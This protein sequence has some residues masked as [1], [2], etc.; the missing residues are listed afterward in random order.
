MTARLNIASVNTLLGER[1]GDLARELVGADPTER[2]RDEWRFR[3]KGSLAVM[4]GGPRRGLW[5]DFECGCGGDPLGLVAHLRR[6]T[7]R[8]AFRWA[9]A[10]L[11]ALPGDVARP[12]ALRPVEPPYARPEASDAPDLRH[13]WS[14]NLGRSLWREATPADAPGSLVPVYLAVRGLAWEPDAPIRF[15]PRAWRNAKYG[16][17]GPAMVALM[18]LPETGEPCGAH[19]TYLRPDGTGKAE[20]ERNKIMLGAAGVIRLVPDT[21][22]TMGLGL[23]EGIETALAAM[24]GA[25]WRPVW[26]ATSA[27]AMDRFPVLPGV[28]ALTVFAD[29]DGPGMDAARACC[30]RWADA[31]RE[32][33]ILAPPAGDWDDVLP[34][35]D[36]AR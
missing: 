23:A 25:G 15:H 20:G 27:G 22:V 7:M 35:P 3:R 8:E 16:S 2:R 36:A 9:L 6:T 34:R 14:V 33:R 19:V 29:A 18:T 31:G 4:V 26:A 24:Q 13:R 1:M 12:D 11:G 5:H 21:E 32:G 17:S 30:R 10:W 28:E